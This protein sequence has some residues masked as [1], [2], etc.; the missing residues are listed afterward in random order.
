[1]LDFNIYK[2][3]DRLYFLSNPDQLEEAKKDI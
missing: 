2:E 1:M 3:N